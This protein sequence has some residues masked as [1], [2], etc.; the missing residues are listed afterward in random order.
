M[1]LFEVALSRLF[2]IKV[3]AQTEQ[4]AARL[5]QFFLGF[6]DSS[7]AFDRYE[8]KFEFKKIDMVENDLIAVDKVEDSSN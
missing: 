7:E 1:P 2:I 4:E 3:E 8:F 6:K 5:S